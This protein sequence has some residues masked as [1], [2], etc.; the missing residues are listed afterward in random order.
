ME[1]ILGVIFFI[2]GVYVLDDA[3]K[4]GVSNQ[5]AWAV[6]TVILWLIVF[7]LY[8][9]RRNALTQ[10]VSNID[11]AEKPN[12]KRLGFVLILL[13]SFTPYLWDKF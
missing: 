4:R 11:G 8:L 13:L 7:P 6:G 5:L 10:T 12:S 9:V 2:S 3:T 1:L